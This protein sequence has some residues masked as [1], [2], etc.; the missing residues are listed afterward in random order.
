M[1]YIGLGPEEGKIVTDKTALS[2]AMVRCGITKGEF[3][4][5]WPEF[6]KMLVDWF[7]S[8]NWL[9]EESPGETIA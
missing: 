8:G 1:E 5:D 4:P 7:Y 9:K 3:G 6:A 2:Y